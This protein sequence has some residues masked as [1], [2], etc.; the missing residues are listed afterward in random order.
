[1]PKKKTDSKKKNRNN[2]KKNSINFEKELAKGRVSYEKKVGDWWQGRAADKAHAKAYSHI[3]DVTEKQFK[4]FQGKVIVDYA[5][6]DGKMLLGMAKRLKGSR[7]IGLDGSKKMLEASA[8][9]LTEAG[10][11]WEMVSPWQLKGQSLPLVSLVHSNLPNFSLPSGIA[12]LLH[13][14]FPNI[15]P[16]DDEQDYYDKHGYLNRRDTAIGKM[17]AR[18]REMDPEDEVSFDDVDVRYEGL[19]TDRVISRHLRHLLKKS[20]LLIKSDYANT[21]REELSQLTQ[22]RT[23]FGEGA[24]EEGI[25]GKNCEAFFRYS[26]S[27]YQR[28]SVILDVFEQTDDPTDKTGGYFVSCFKAI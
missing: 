22:W 21:H 2:S 23:L 4:N 24:L 25:K 3:L 15:A 26:E 17:L 28:S 5:C 6:G 27:D 14:T 20:G 7:I 11:E 8:K 10:V 13:F 18:F 12:N 9:R 19:M 16:S 1:M